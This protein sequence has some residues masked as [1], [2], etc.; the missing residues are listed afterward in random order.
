[1]GYDTYCFMPIPYRLALSWFLAT[2]V[3]VL[4]AGLMVGLIIGKQPSLAEVE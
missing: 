2:L 1:M 3:E 4:T